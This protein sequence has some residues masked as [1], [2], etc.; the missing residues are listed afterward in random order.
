MP[1]GGERSEQLSDRCSLSAHDRF[2]IGNHFS[3]EVVHG[4]VTMNQCE[5]PVNRMVYRLCVGA[6][7]SRGGRRSH[8][9]IY[10]LAEQKTGSLVPREERDP[11]PPLP[12]MPCS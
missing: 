5:K 3:E 6:G 9:V 11:I 7:F 4:A 10:R 12:P 8:R 2:N 1:A